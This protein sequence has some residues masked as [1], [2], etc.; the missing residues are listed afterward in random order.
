MIRIY[1]MHAPGLGDYTC[2]AHSLRQARPMLREMVDPGCSGDPGH[3]ALRDEL[4]AEPTYRRVLDAELDELREDMLD[5]STRS[6]RESLAAHRAG[7]NDPQY[8]TVPL[9]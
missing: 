9:E 2:F 4:G 1:L 8:H 3:A 6:F 5:G 7:A